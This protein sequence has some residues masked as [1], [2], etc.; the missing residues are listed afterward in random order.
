MSVLVLEGGAVVV[1]LLVAM[2]MRRQQMSWRFVLTSS[3]I[4]LAAF[5]AMIVTW[6]GR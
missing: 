5:T 1:T 3:L 2:E 6:R 4:M